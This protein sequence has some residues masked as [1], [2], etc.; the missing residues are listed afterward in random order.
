M[1]QDQPQDNNHSPERFD[2]NTSVSAEVAVLGSMLINP[3]AV[4]DALEHLDATDFSLDS[5]QRIY[6]S[7]KRLLEQKHA[8]D[9]I[10]VMNELQRKSE[11]QSIGGPAYLA[12]LSED[13]PRNMNI[14]S[15]VR[16]VK[17][18]AMLRGVITISTHASEEASAGE[19]SA[20]DIASR[21]MAEL[22][23]LTELARDTTMEHFGAY[24]NH[25][26]KENNDDVF[27]HS[28]LVDGTA[29]GF[30]KFDQLT[31]TPQ[32]GELWI[33]AGRASMG[34]T[35]WAT[36]LIKNAV[37]RHDPPSVASFFMEQS[38]TSAMG[39]LLCGA[40]EADF[41]RYRRNELFDAE[42]RR[43]R[44]AMADF[45][46]APLYWCGDSNLTVT[47]IRAKCRR[48]KRDLAAQGKKLNLIIIDQLSFI[49]SS[50]FYRKGMQRDELVG[51]KVKLLKG[52][53]KELDVPGILLAQVNRGATKNKDM[54]PTLADLAESGQIE[55]HADGVMF[56]HRQEYYDRH[57]LSL[58]N[59]GQFIVAKNRD[60]DTGELAVEYIKESCLWLDLPPAVIPGNSSNF[61]FENAY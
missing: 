34:K 52:V 25:R 59:K 26:Y 16:I 2:I 18:K 50:D 3:L 42:K 60:G 53:M 19:E 23:A 27:T 33:I 37:L 6:R 55:Q 15:Y 21:Q 24:L 40:A 38:K 46:K 5:H 7:I 13:V 8:V 61:D 57:D 17:D 20:L 51:E 49:S 36:S 9:L 22:Q 11:L 32:P 1:S 39:R 44:E 56:L 54:I 30:H 45:R 10:T 47:E 31:S 28:A 35:A 58:R 12:Y 4:E 41:K 48:L 14:E 29:T 43:I